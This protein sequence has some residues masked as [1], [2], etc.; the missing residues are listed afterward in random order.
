LHIGLSTGH[1]STFTVGNGGNKPDN[2]YLYANELISINGLQFSGKVDDV[3]MDAITINLKNVTFPASAEVML[4]SQNGT[5]DFNTFDNPIKKGVN[6]TNVF[7]QGIGSAALQLT[8]FDDGAA[9][10]INSNKRL[11]NKTPMISI[12]DF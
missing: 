11:E 4:R 1:M 5:L 10:R 6:L 9:G 8:D 12:R 2:V 7:H 3:Y